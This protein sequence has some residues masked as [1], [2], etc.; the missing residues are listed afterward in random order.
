[1]EEKCCPQMRRA[2]S[3][4]ACVALVV[5]SSSGAAA[6]DL[7]G[8][9]FAKA[10]STAPT[11]NWSGVY[12]G[13]HVGYAWTSASYATNHVNSCNTP[14]TRFANPCDPAN[15]SPA[16]LI[17]GGQVGARW[18]TGAW[19]FGVEGTWTSANLS[20]TTASV[21]APGR[22][23]YFTKLKDYYTATAQ[24]GYA[25]DSVLVY[26]KGGYA[27]GH[28]GLNSSFVPADIRT[29]IPAS[30]T[31]NGWA[32]G[33]GAEFSLTPNF[34]VGLEY[35][36]IHLDAGSI[37][38][39]SPPG[40]GLVFDCTVPDFVKLKYANIRDNIDQVMFRANYRFNWLA[41][42]AGAKQ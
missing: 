18:Q 2:R 38:V 9:P 14:T 19:V 5:A 42:S 40:S 6:A 7:A 17:A 32:V 29:S 28:L 35:N 11:I 39:C 13:P 15:S 10:P 34:S 27:G 3:I 8:R 30:A 36:H 24:V 21:L 37:S 12:I 25:W 16:G 41:G 33:G 23:E 1:M 22:I 20:Q 4:M 26:A 31:G